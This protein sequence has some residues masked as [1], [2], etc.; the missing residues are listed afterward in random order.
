[1]SLLDK[2]VRYK[3]GFVETGVNILTQK[4]FKTNPTEEQLV[5]LQKM[6]DQSGTVYALL[7]LMLGALGVLIGY[8]MAH[9]EIALELIKKDAT[10]GTG[11]SL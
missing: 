10:A 6:S 5:L 8:G 3:Q 1:M 11:I 9:I 2:Y 7:A 4:F